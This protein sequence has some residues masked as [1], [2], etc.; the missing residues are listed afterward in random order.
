MTREKK[1]AEETDTTSAA[2]AMPPR[3]PSAPDPVDEVYS[4][5]IGTEA[6]TEQDKDAETTDAVITEV[7]EEAADE[8]TTAPVIKDTI[9][10]EPE[11]TDAEITEAEKEAADEDDEVPC[12]KCHSNNIDRS[13]EY[14]GEYTCLDCGHIWQVGGED[15]RV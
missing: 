10:T 13:R 5:Y 9:I 7:E 8:E 3:K 15:W 14:R 2:D 6:S 11:T 12:P 1:A 4:K